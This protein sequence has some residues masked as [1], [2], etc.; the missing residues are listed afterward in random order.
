[1]KLM[2]VL[3]VFATLWSS[4][5]FG[6]M[7]LGSIP[8][9]CFDEDQYC[10]KST[11]E[12]G[13]DENNK[14]TLTVFVNFYAQ[15]SMD[16]YG[17]VE[18]LE[19]IFTDF[20]AWV[21]YVENSKNVKYKFSKEMPS[22]V[23]PDGRFVRITL[24]DYEMRRPFG[25]EQVVEQSEYIKVDPFEGASISYQLTLDKTYP[26]TVGIEDKNGH[27]HVAVD[28]DNGYFNIHINLAIKPTIKI[29][30]KAT[31]KV[32]TRGMTDIFKGM[33]DLVD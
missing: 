23:L 26:G 3:F 24:S 16:D 20:P 28:E 14:K 4:L 33:F 27:I 1:M 6:K 10:S 8:E 21:D 31:S 11:W 13:R 25:W 30:P 9:G 15:L 22:K 5:A 12:R 29:L 2:R 7:V 18:E 32:I 17:S 19:E